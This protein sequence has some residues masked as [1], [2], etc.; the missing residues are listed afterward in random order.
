MAASQ[1]PVI[2]APP[3]RR[4]LPAPDGASARVGSAVRGWRPGLAAWAV[5]AEQVTGLAVQRLAEPG[6]GAEPDR[7]GV[8]V[9]QDRQVDHADADP[10]GELRQGHVP[11]GEELVEVGDDG[12]TVGVR[13][14]HYTVPSRSARMPA[15]TRMMR[16]KMIKPRPNQ[17]TGHDIP[18]DGGQWTQSTGQVTSWPSRFSRANP[19]ATQATRAPASSHQ[20]RISTSRA[21]WA[22]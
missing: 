4:R 8:T 19:S 18:Q 14:R 3:G 2:A 9:F 1:S 10:F 20:P 15:L 13:G 6:Q 16:A 21:A 5:V 11:V 17:K 7:P 12:M 22:V